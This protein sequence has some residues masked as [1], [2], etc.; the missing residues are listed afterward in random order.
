MSSH[1]AYEIAPDF[2]EDDLVATSGASLLPPSRE[3]KGKGRALSPD[4]LAGRIGGGAPGAVGE[5]TTR[6]S[7]GGVQTETRCA[8]FGRNLRCRCASGC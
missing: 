5:R 6:S 7:I 4:P 8:R 1:Q 2:D 3:A